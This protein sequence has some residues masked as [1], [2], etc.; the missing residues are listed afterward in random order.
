VQFFI[1]Y[2]GA[3][4]AWAE[5]LAWQLE[6]AG[7]QA[8]VQAWD[9]RPGENF[10]ANMRRALDTADRTLAV[11]S[12][13]YL[14]SVYG[15]DEWTAAFVHDHADMTGLL[16]VRVEEVPLPRLLRP[17][18]YIDLAGM[19]AE[20]AAQQLL[21]GLQRGRRKP[22]QPP[23][24][25]RAATRAG[26]PSFPGRGPAI[27]NLPPRNPA[28][29]GRDNL[30]AQLHAQLARSAGGGGPVA[31]VAQALYGLGGVG[32]T[33]LALEYAHRFAGD[34][35]L[36]WWIPSENSL[37]IPAA[38]ARLASKFGIA[39]SAD[40][41][42]VVAA[43]L[44][45]LRTRDRWLLVFDNA[46]QPADLARWQPT[47]GGGHVLVTSRNPAWGAL[48]QAV[49][50]D[51]LPREQA[52][53]LL[54]R[55]T[56]DKDRASAAA[57][58]ESLGDLPLALEQAAAYLEQTGM[59]LAAYLAA[60]RRRHQR[61][62]AKGTPVA[63]QGQVDTTWQLS[64]DQVAQMVPAGVELLRLC[65][66][67]AS[68]TIPLDLVTVDPGLLPGALAAA[69][70]ADDEVGVEEAAGACY[71]YSL[72]DRDLA[73]I[74]VHR[75]VQ[76]VMRAQ[77]AEPE[78]Q[79]TITTV[80]GLRAARFPSDDELGDPKRWPRCA[81]LLPHLLAAT[82]HAHEAATAGTT[83]VG[84]LGRAGAYLEGRGAYEP[85]RGLL[86]RTLTLAE[87]G[88][89]SDHPEVGAILAK[90]GEVL[91]D[92]GHLTSARAVLE[93]ALEIFEAT[94]GPDSPSVGATLSNLGRVLVTQ[95]DL[96]GARSALE[97]ALAITKAAL[98][99]E[100]PEVGATLRNLG[101]VLAEQGDLGGAQAAHEAALKIFGAAVG[102]DHPE[103][104]T[105]LTNLGKVLH[106]QGDLPGARV[107][108]ERAVEIFEAA[109]GPDS[110]DVAAPLSNLGRVL[111]DQGDLVGARAA[112][113]RA[114]AITETAL[115]ADH[116]WVGAA[117]VN[118]G[119]VLSEQGDLVGG[120][121]QLERA[122]AIYQAALGPDHLTTQAVARRLGHL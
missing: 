72:V 120:Q 24:F 53:E 87:A 111:H 114:L 33:Q 73:G 7:H 98:G 29:T 18:I 113:E 93:R 48:G 36:T 95:G 81:Q 4:Q 5:W 25:P 52:V 32:K 69:V 59:P 45:V 37:M 62:L 115:G 42:E 92:Q 116:L 54:L 3:D 85:A 10:V 118:L 28:F 107:S 108:L 46:Q 16:V 121:V 77:L 38:L 84:L 102:A 13:A 30:L 57:L 9:F 60:Y 27:W 96:A 75:L 65:A 55:R 39:A 15:S 2:T 119:E 61:L 70:A 43:V 23:A 31:V 41:E 64:I 12:A 104:A 89:G 22:D 105:T 106:E 103:V 68:D 90:L 19:D 14:E 8:V 122:H 79:A 97:R 20:T 47:G 91:L 26:G 100:H 86:E 110:S 17:W 56:P 35:D 49:R 40:Q 82:E 58:A 21:Q 78:R 63:Y 11:V 109:L 6:A 44:D 34:Y 74:R 117:R 112:L 50:V 71:R 94:L 80:V 101:L 66:F 67:L 83:A 1:S 88:L 51:V 76:Q 99:P